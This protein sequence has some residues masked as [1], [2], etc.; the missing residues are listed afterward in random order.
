MAQ[1]PNDPIR[2]RLDQE[3]LRRFEADA[4]GRQSNV[5]PLDAARNEG[6]FYGQL[7]RGER[8]LNGVQRVGFFLVG[9]LFCLW[10][11]F[12][13]IGMFPRLFRF[14]GLAVTPMGDNSVSFVYLPLAALALLLGLKILGTAL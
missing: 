7:I 9:T 12:I 13:A 10:S 5:P 8:P 14:I 11:I 2:P 6:R 4:M 3:S 1:E